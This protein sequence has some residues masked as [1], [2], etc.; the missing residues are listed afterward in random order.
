VYLSITD[1]S[2]LL[3]HLYG[4]RQSLPLLFTNRAPTSPARE[5]WNWNNAQG[6]PYMIV[7]NYVIMI[8]RWVIFT[9]HFARSY[10]TCSICTYSLL[11]N[12]WISEQ[13]TLVHQ[14][15]CI[16]SHL[17]HLYGRSPVRVIGLQASN[18]YQR[19]PSFLVFC[20]LWF[21][22]PTLHVISYRVHP[23]S[24]GLSSLSLLHYL[25]LSHISN[26]LFKLFV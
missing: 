1:E 20:I 26:I 18:L 8:M 25:L 16:N 12:F 22:A 7:S 5:T 3:S 21:K 2:L 9:S 13:C 17:S 6:V 23:S 10:C 11:C 19:P 15:V 4:I 24:F 14:I